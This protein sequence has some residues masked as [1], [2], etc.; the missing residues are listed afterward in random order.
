[1]RKSAYEI[2]NVC[3]STRISRL[4]RLDISNKSCK[5]S[6]LIR[7]VSLLMMNERKSHQ[8]PSTKTRPNSATSY[9]QTAYVS[10]GVQYVNEKTAQR[11]EGEGETRVP[12]SHNDRFRA[13]SRRPPPPLSR[14]LH[15]L[16]PLNA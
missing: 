14:S 9:F 16:L 1:M 13:A 4:S 2:L 11:A 7:R 3:Q 8:K 12:V 5:V 6:N 15:T 10:L